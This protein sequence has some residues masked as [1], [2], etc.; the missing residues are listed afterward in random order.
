M[1][2]VKPD[3]AGRV[4][5]PNGLIPNWSENHSIFLFPL[6]WKRSVPVPNEYQMEAWLLCEIDKN[7]DSQWIVSPSQVRSRAG[8]EIS[9]SDLNALI[10]DI[11]IE[12]HKNGM[13]ITLP[14]FLR[15]LG[16][17][18]SAGQVT[19]LK[20][21]INGLSIWTEKSFRHLFPSIAKYWDNYS[22]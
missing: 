22:D 10:F 15:E 11:K 4:R 17:L 14:K 13:R 1:K 2:I 21:E 9:A 18:P 19:V 8:D 12:E 20:Q 3:E 16:W 5:I 7:Q 6:H